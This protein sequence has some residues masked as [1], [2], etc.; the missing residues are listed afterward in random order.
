M[1]SISNIIFKEMRTFLWI[2]I[3]LIVLVVSA[4]SN[5]SGSRDKN[6]N[7][8]I[9]VSGFEKI[10][11]KLQI[12][13]YNKASDFPE[14]GKE[15]KT[16]RVTVTSGIVKYTFN[17]PPGDYAAALYH[18]ENSDGECNTNFLGI[19]TEA[20][21]FSNNVKPVLSAPSFDETKVSVQKDEEIAIQRIH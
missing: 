7:L 13:L 18:D 15:Y 5:F 21:G 2:A 17:I 11:G 10:C 20:Y 3:F 16:T 8:T 4:F 19:P 14:K 9:K 6:V 1:R 12:G